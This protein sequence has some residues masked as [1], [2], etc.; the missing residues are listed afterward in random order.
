[1]APLTLSEIWIYPIKSLGGIRLRKSEVK[2]KGLLYDRRW[3]LI[4]DAGIFITQ[5][6]HSIMAFFKLSLAG[7]QFTVNFKGDYIHLPADAPLSQVPITATIWDDTIEVHEVLGEYSLWFSQRLGMNCRLVY[8]PEDNQRLVDEK[9]RLENNSVSLADGYPFLI[10]GQSS[11]DDLNARLENPVPMNRFR[12]NFVFTGGKPYE[13]DQWKNFTI[14]KNRFVG[15]KPCGRCGLPTVNQETGERGT[16]PLATLTTYRRMNN[17]VYF[18]QNLLAIDCYEIHEG[19]K[20][21]LGS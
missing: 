15:V 20:I 1:M 6:A 14:G 21:E 7:D 13:E 10:I 19:D 8:F 12:P 5:R 3:M 18:G 2:P 11:L 16:E 17:K 9:Y 4:D